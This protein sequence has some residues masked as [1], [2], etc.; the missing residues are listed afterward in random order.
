MGYANWSPDRIR[1]LSVP[2]AAL[3]G[4]LAF[5]ALCALLIPHMESGLVIFPILVLPGF[6]TGGVWFS[7][8]LLAWAMKKSRARIQT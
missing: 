8:R 3:V 7:V 2:V 6:I 1:Q 4:I 5:V